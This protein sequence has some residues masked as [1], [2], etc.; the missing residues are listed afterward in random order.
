MSIG[1]T[2]AEARQHAGLTVAD[3]S[4]RTRIRQ[5]LIRAIEHDEFD[6]CGG[7]FYARGHIRAI[8]AVVG[9]DPYRLIGEYDAAR[10][11]GRPVTLEELPGR[12]SRTPR[13]RGRHPWLAPVAYA[14]CLALISFA[15]IRLT[16]ITRG[17]PPA[18]TPRGRAAARTPVAAGGPHSAPVSSPAVPRP[19]TARA[20]A[21]EVTP[22]SAAAFGPGGTSDGDD[23]QGAPLALAGAP[24]TPWHTDWYTTARFGNLQKGTGLLLGLGRTVPAASV[25]IRL[26]SIPGADLQLRAGTALT[27]MPVVATAADAGGT[28]RLRLASH[29]RI[30]YLLIW[31]T[32]LPPDPAGTYQADV[33]SVTVS[34]PAQAAP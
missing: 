34:E 31:F 15:A 20:P 5:G 16:P 22:V 11:S 2:L 32:L 33:S 7:D 27:D 26:G 19:A 8:A 14:L 6:A 18:S 12:S 9:A 25:T 23:P 17:S 24:A 13:G 4:A 1:G 28:V 10:P 21:A 30:R 29:P 3:V